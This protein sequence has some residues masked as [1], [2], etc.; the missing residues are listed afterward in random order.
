MAKKNRKLLFLKSTN[1]LIGEITDL[2]PMDV[3]DLT[4]FNTLD[5]EIDEAAGEYFYGTY[6]Q[7]EIRNRELNPVVT[8]TMVKYLTNVK[9]LNVYPI[10]K[11]LNILINVLKNN[12][13]IIKTDE[14]NE[15]IEF[16]D[17]QK[18]EHQLKIASYSNTE[19][20]HWVSA[21]EEAAVNEAKAGVN[22]L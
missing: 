3:Y 18:Q 22:L 15:M 21:E 4:K 11:Q 2:T 20:F 12:Q 6:D 7:W 8:E 5:V 1:A 14:F 19:M 9:I 13:S 16:L 17:A 10:H